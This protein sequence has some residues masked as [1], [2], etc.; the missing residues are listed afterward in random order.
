MSVKDSKKLQR[1][2]VGYVFCSPGTSRN[3]GVITL[4]NKHLQFKCIKEVK[5]E[6]GQC[7]IILAEVQGRKLI[8]ANSYAPNADDPLFD[9]CFLLTLNVN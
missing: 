5:D 7:L 2:W 1:G 9:P 3:R 6:E 8:L 4:V